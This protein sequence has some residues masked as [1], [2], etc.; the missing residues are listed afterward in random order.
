MFYQPFSS[1]TEISQDLPNLS[2]RIFEA[3]NPG[4]IV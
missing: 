2:F 4:P 1:V 3:N